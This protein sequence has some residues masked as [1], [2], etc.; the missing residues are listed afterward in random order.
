MWYRFE[1][2]NPM[3]I[4]RIKNYQVAFYDVNRG[5]KCF[6]ESFFKPDEINNVITYVETEEDENALDNR[7]RVFAIFDNDDVYELKLEKMDSNRKRGNFYDYN[8]DDED[9]YI[10]SFINEYESETMKFIWGV[11]SWDDLCNCDACLYT[12]N[13]IDLIYLKDENKY[14]LGIETIFGFDKE[15]HKLSYLKGCLDAFTKFMVDNGYDTEVKPQWWDVF[16]S[17][18]NTHF[19]SIEECYGMFKF[20]VNGYRNMQEVDMHE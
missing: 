8:E 13:D 3:G 2:G 11:K 18:M 6:D 19:D 20:L 7:C 16:M 5:Y 17:G 9:D 15:E 14:I 1:D 10:D 12:M 4:P